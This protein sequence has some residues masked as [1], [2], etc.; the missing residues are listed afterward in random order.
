MRR[1]SSVASV[2]TKKRSVIVLTVIPKNCLASRILTAHN[3][4]VD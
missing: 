2:L 1:M 4:M 3:F